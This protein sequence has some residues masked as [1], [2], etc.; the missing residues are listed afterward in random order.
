[1]KAGRIIAI[2]IFLL[3]LVSGALLLQSCTH[4]GQVALQPMPMSRENAITEAVRKA[5]PAAV[6]VNVIK[7]EVV[8]QR[9]NPMY[10]PFFGF[11][12]VP[13]IRNVQG[14]GTGVIFDENGFIIT[15]AHVVEGA[16]QIKVILTD[17]RQYNAQIIGMDSVQD[18]AILKVDGTDLPVA[19]LGT[20][21]DLIIGEW[22]IAVGNP[23][24]FLIKDSHPSVSVGVISAID[25][26][27]A[28]TVENDKVFKKMIQTDAAINPGNSGGPLLNINGE[29][30]G[31]NT[32]I[33]SESGES[34]GIGFAI[35]IDRVKKIAKEL[36]LYGKMR[37]R[38]FGFRMSDLN[39]MLASQFNLE[40]LNGV[41]VVDVEHGGPA[42][43]AGLSV[44]DIIVQI[45]DTVINDSDDVNLA[46][47]DVAVG[48]T[49]QLKVQRNGQPLTMQ[50]EI[51]EL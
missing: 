27:F 16:T 2:L 5:S 21:G 37:D 40:S 19:T 9:I 14:I 49:I 36:M 31:I 24:A 22:A 8:N 20:S 4:S 17:N 35:P 23:Y 18:I 12:D 13:H 3:G 10:S 6:S 11:F 25:R 44:G 41:L 39:P 38:H 1:M 28:Q 46:V 33:F 26:N 43:A 32:F 7:T 15:N 30:I 29:V 45:N 42:E 47:L 51:E 34:V 48:E 50:M